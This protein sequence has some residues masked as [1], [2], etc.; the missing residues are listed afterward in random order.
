VQLVETLRYKPEGCGLNSPRGQW[1]FQFTH[2]FQPHY[3]PAVDS[4]SER[5]EYRESSWE[6]KVGRR[7]RPPSCELSF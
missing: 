7:V 5:K 6:L 4:A 2:S 1:I 3:G